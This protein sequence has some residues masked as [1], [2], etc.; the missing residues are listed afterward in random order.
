MQNQN[1]QNVHI[2]MGHLSVDK[3][4]EYILDCTGFLKW[5]KILKYTQK[6]YLK[7]LTYPLISSEGEGRL[8]SIPKGNKSFQSLHIDHYG[9]LLWKNNLFFK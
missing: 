9:S 3:T 2:C 6:N 4:L 8:H 5:K 1:I 7:C